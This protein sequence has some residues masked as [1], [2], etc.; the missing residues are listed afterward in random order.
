MARVLLL[1]DAVEDLADP[2][3]S[4]RK[5]V[6]KALKKLRTDPANR[7]APLGSA[8][9][10]FRKLVVGNRQFRIVYRVESDDTVVVVWV[11]ATRAAAPLPADC[12]ASLPRRTRIRAARGP[13]SGRTGREAE[14]RRPCG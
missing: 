14:R 2:D 5:L 10:T 7:G 12:S 13:K 6:F 1:P 8:L 11:I 4:V 3:G 9:T